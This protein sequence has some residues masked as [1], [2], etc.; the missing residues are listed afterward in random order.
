MPAHRDVRPTG[1]PRCRL[2][3]DEDPRERSI[4]RKVRDRANYAIAL[5]APTMDDEPHSDTNLCRKAATRMCTIQRLLLAQVRNRCLDICGDPDR[6][7]ALRV[8]G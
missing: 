7:G 5:A 8:C 3:A 1:A 6:L 4:Y 2:P